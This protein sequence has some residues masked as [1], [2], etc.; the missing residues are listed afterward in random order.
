V[1]QTVILTAVAFSG[2]GY[3]GGLPNMISPYLIEPGNTEFQ[4]Q[5]RFLGDAFDDV[6]DD[7]FGADMGANISLG[8]RSFITPGVEMDLTHVRTGGEYTAGAGYN[9]SLSGSPV[10]FH[11]SAHWYSTEITVDERESGFFALAS[12]EAGRLGDVVVL[13][14]NFGRDFRE[15]RTILGFGAD[16]AL[17]E[18]VS[19][20][21]EY[22][23]ARDGGD[24]YPADSLDSWCAGTRINTW[25]HQFGLVLGN[26][27]ALGPRSLAS[28]TASDD[29]HLGITIRRLLAI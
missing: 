16:A 14:V 12:L 24:D 29:L 28:G 25:G 27:W 17:N 6:I 15:E 1:F 21:G 10:D 3:E 22:W 7:F 19:I 5:H 26:S 9:G 23:P 11:V 2:T 20:Q 13:A 8:L 18:S 4:I